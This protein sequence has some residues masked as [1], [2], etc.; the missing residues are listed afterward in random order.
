MDENRIKSGAMVSFRRDITE[1][2]RVSEEQSGASTIYPR[3]FTGKNEFKLQTIHN[4]PNSHNPQTA[5]LNLTK[6]LTPITTKPTQQTLQT[7]TFKQSN[8]MGGPKSSQVSYSGKKISNSRL[9]KRESLKNS[10]D[11]GWGKLKV[12]GNVLRAHKYNPD[13]RVKRNIHRKY[14]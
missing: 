8:I 3:L 10:A 14:K 13:E 11:K 7:I 5:F 1:Q 2:K 12:R 9:K 4:Q 6:S